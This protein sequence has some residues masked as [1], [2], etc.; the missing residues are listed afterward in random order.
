[1]LVQPKIVRAS[2]LYVGPAVIVIGALTGFE[3]YGIGG[4]IYGAALTVLG[5]AVIDATAD[6]PA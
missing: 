3:L 1:M 4:A 2:G 6:N 5:V